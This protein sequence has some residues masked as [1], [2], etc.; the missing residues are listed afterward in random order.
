MQT[1]VI[2]LNEYKKNK[3]Y[4]EYLA[5][6]EALIP[7]VRQIKMIELEL[8][9]ASI[10]LFNKENELFGE[11]EATRRRLIRHQQRQGK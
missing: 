1:K 11:A 9:E 5:K 7:Y 4:R 6:E 2:D 3:A 8:T 10:A